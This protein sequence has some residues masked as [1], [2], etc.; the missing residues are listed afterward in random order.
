MMAVYAT[1]PTSVRHKTASSLFRAPGLV[2]QSD[3]FP[4]YMALS[5]PRLL[6]HRLGNRGL[7][8]SKSFIYVLNGIRFASVRYT[9]S[10]LN[11][12]EKRT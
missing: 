3:T 11:K 8:R 10:Y 5:N 4:R 6:S 1:S 12:G 9:H 2:L 7:V